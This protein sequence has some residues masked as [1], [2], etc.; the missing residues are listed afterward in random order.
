MEIPI[1]E[2]S[3]TCHFKSLNQDLVSDI[4]NRLDGSTLAATSCT[5]SHLRDASTD[6]SLWQ[7]LCHSTWPST[8]LPEAQRLISIN[9]FARFYADSTPMVL[10]DDASLTSLINHSPARISSSDITS[11]VDVYYKGKCV[12]SRVLYGIP[13][14]IDVFENDDNRHR[15]FSN[16][17]FKLDL[18][19]FNP[20][21]NTGNES[22]MNNVQPGGYLLEK[23]AEEVRLSW[24]LYDKKRG[25]A[26]NLSSTEPLMVQ[27]SWSSNEDYVMNF[28]C[29]VP[30][31]EN[32]VPHKLVECMITAQCKMIRGGE[33]MKLTETSMSLVDIEGGHINGRKSLTVLSE[34]LHSLRSNRKVEV[35]KGYKM[36]KR[37]RE[38]I[39]K[40]NDCRESI[41]EKLCASVEIAVFV[42]ICYACNALF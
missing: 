1:M 36:F 37:Q 9:S 17:P 42:A 6:P 21:K 24:V 31:E 22:N 25:K 4:M 30:V 5:C 34:A 2:D 29:V 16:C 15:W 33:G 3:S 20:C 28:G 11:F 39:K 10:Y 8:S 27:K 40:R 23:L 7:R 19:G 14:A 38:E 32:A 12:L 35:E 13:N 18:L 26:V 41:A